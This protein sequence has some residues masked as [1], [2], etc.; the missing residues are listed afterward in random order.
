M[1]C[2]YGRT[3]AVGIQHQ[4]FH[5]CCAAVSAAFEV[6]RKAVQLSQH[7]SK[8]PSDL[9]SGLSSSYIWLFCKLNPV[10]SW[11]QLHNCRCFL[12]HL[13][14]L[15]QSLRAPCLAPGGSGSIKKYLETLLRSPRVSRRIACCV[16]TDLHFADESS[17]R[18]WE[19]TYHAWRTSFSW[20][21]VH[22]SVVWVKTAALSRGKPMSASSNL[23]RMK[24]LILERVKDFETKAML[25]PTKCPPCGQV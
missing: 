11:M 17:G 20:L 18:H 6:S 2:G 4:V 21:E 1:P 15:L 13:R 14:M 22:S 10:A 5:R 25:E 12:E 16:Q 19:T 23:E 7:L 24:V 3:T 8:S 9:H